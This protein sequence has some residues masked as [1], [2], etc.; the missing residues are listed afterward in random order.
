MHRQIWA[1]CSWSNGTAIIE[2]PFLFRPIRCV[3]DL[4]DISV[5]LQDAET[6]QPVDDAEVNVRMT[7]GDVSGR[8]IHAVATQ[9]AATN[10]LLRSA[11]DR[12]SRP[13]FVGR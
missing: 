5:L 7:S 4:I 1:G 2:F 9:A 6:G 10:K 13:L 11:L 8:T 12:A 3:P